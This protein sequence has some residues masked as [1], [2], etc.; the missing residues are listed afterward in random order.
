MIASPGKLKPVSHGLFF[1]LRNKYIG[2]FLGK[3]EMVYVAA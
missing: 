2:M 1:Y 3:L